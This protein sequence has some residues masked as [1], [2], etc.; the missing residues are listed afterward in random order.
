M[1][2][3]GRL[4]IKQIAEE[5]LA[6]L[7]LVVVIIVRLSMRLRIPI[8]GKALGLPIGIGSIFL[9]QFIKFATVEPYTPTFRTVVD[10]NILAF[11]DK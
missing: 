9:N 3:E 10:F 4:K 11:A 5:R 1:C 8:V 2:R 6:V 7:L